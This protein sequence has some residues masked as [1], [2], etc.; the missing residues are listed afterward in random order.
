MKGQFCKHCKS[1]R[2]G[3]SCV[4]VA[5]KFWPNIFLPKCFVETV[6]SS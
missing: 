1:W 2:D 3:N 4:E 6:V 5:A